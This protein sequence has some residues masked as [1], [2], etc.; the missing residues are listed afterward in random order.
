MSF[1]MGRGPF[2][3]IA[4]STLNNSV[5]TQQQRFATISLSKLSRNEKAFHSN[6][7]LGRGRS[8]GKGKTSGRGQKGYYARSGASGLIWYEGGQTPLWRRTPKFGFKNV[9][10]RPLQVI[11][12]NRLSKWVNA[13]R[14]DATKTITIGDMVRSRLV[15]GRV[16]YGVKLLAN[17]ASDSLRCPIPLNVEVTHS[18]RKA[19]DYLRAN[20]GDIKFVYHSRLTLRELLKPGSLGHYTP[21]SHAVPPPRLSLRYEHQL[22][23]REDLA[24]AEQLRLARIVR[25]IRQRH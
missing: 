9:N 3:A 23:G 4:R 15:H 17:N 21:A 2:A 12:I 24:K 11:N 22:C 6:K 20:G 8:S 7:R 18:T 5:L 25:K 14:I 1:A 19:R 13:G 16:K 10:A